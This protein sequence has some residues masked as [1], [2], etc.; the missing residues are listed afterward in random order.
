MA[1][2][3]ASN[4]Y[5]V[6][7][8][9]GRKAFFF[10]KKKQKTFSPS[11]AP[12]P[13]LLLQAP[14]PAIRIDAVVQAR[15]QKLFGPFSRKR[16]T[17]LLALASHLGSLRKRTKKRSS[18]GLHNGIDPCC[19]FLAFA[20]AGAIVVQA[21]EQRFLSFLHLK[22]P[23]TMTRTLAFDLD[24]TLTDSAPDIAAAVNRT[25]TARGLPELLLARNHRNGRRRPAPPDRTRLRSRGQQTRQGRS[26]RLPRGLRVQRG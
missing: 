9:P 12:R 8:S 26:R 7:E 11:P 23:A 5:C 19:R 15:R 18:S 10:A 21:T 6:G 2:A 25:L 3:A 20:E 17:F 1:T 4:I 16:T 14:S 13:R 24:G 22:A